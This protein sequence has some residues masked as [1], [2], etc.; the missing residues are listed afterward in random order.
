MKFVKDSTN[1]LDYHTHNVNQVLSVLILDYSL[2]QEVAKFA[3]IPRANVLHS[4][5]SM[6]KC[7]NV[8]MQ[9]SANYSVLSPLSKIPLTAAAVIILKII[10][11]FL[12]IQKELIVRMVHQMISK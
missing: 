6:M 1:Q 7:A 12:H 5:F 9:F 10:I 2:F 3:P 8:L 4:H 11:D